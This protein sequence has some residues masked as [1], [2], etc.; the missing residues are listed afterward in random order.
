MAD[1]LTL[2]PPAQ[3]RDLLLSQVQPLLSDIEE[4]SL[5]DSAGRICAEDVFAPHPLPQFPR[6]TVDGYAV[7]AKDTYGASESMPAYI[8]VAGEVLMGSRPTVSVG[9]GMA[10]I[11]HTGGML[12]EGCDAVLMLEYTQEVRNGEIEVSRAVAPGENIITVGE[13]VSQ[14]Q[15][16]IPRGTFLRPTEVGGLAALGIL[17]LRVARKVKIGIISTGDEVVPVDADIKPGQV[18][19][20]NSYTLAGLVKSNGAE[21]VL[22]GIVSDEVDD[23]FK[24]ARSA[25]T[26]CDAV[27]ITAG[28][29]ASSRDKTAMVINQLGKPGVLVHGINTRPGKPTILG[30]CSG[31]AV[32]GL[33]GNPVSAFVN[34]IL[35]V[36]PLIDKLSGIIGKKPRPSVK[37]SLTVNLASQAG[38]EDWQPVKLTKDGSEW[39][40]D[41]VFGK[42]NLIFTLSFSDGLICISPEKTGMSVGDTV[43]VFLF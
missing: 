41:P 9:A 38:R 43:D 8:K 11:I 12:P 2:I 22:Y 40:A 1:F 30:I 33:P 32:V 34:G 20:V 19:D 24:V 35:F 6:S 29:S 5:I 13:D 42:S 10:T 3:A 37:A 25:L 17:K 14:G 4:V 15:L 7:R 39:K 16:V 21:S 36:V 18:R 23:L 26:E 28:S 31:K 27:L